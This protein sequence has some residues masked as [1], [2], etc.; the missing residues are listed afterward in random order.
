[1]GEARIS[2]RVAFILLMS[3]NDR[4]RLRVAF[5]D[6]PEVWSALIALTQAAASYESG[7]VNGTEIAISASP[8]EDSH[9]NTREA[10]RRTGKS[11]RVITKAIANGDLKA[12]RGG[13]WCVHA[14]DLATWI[15]NM[16]RRER[17]R[18]ERTAA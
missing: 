17:R 14:E 11:E 3:L 4:R 10:A 5:R 8:G 6:D 16:D 18:R 9:M 7:S 12:H 13:G 1:M 15:F 2:P